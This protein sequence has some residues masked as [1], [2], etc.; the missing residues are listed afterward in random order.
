MPYIV[1]VMT[2]NENSSVA[3]SSKPGHEGLRRLEEALKVKRTKQ[4]V[5]FTDTG[6]DF[7]LNLHN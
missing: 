2:I 1:N 4:I 6:I 5:N 7:K 3:E